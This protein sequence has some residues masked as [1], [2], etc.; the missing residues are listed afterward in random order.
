M[1]CLPT[2]DAAIV[3][4]RVQIVRALRGLVA[5]GNVIDDEVRLAA[6]E[7]DALTAYRQR[8]LVVVLPETTAEVAAVLAFAHRGV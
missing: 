3:E 6:Y 7:T 8:P 2:P 5:A 1:I 4:R